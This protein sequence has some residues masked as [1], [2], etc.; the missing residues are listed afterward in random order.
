MQKQSMKS[1]TQ[2]HPEEISH[3]MR[4]ILFVLSSRMIILERILSNS[5]VFNEQMAA[6]EHQMDSMR[7]VLHQACSLC[8]EFLQRPSVKASLTADLTKIAHECCDMISPLLSDHVELNIDLKHSVPLILCDPLSLNRVLLNLMK[9]AIESMRQRGGTLL[10]STGQ[11]WV[12]AKEIEDAIYDGDRNPGTYVYVEI[13]DQG[14]GMDVQKFRENMCLSL[15]SK[16]VGHGYGLR[17]VMNTVNDLCGFMHVRSRLDEGTTMRVWF[18]CSTEDVYFMPEDKLC[19]GAGD[20]VEE[21]IQNISIHSRQ[22]NGC[23]ATKQSSRE[24]S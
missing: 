21:I 6:I 24:S 20:Q 13:K 1:D 11:T 22:Q 8:D 17:S 12:Q 16:G 18:P 19:Q 10:L 14:C 3:D 5:P 2:M 15:S 4:N 7:T 9:N 23:I